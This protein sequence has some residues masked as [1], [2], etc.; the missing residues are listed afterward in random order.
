MKT[1]RMPRQAVAADKAWITSLYLAS[2]GWWE[3][4]NSCY[5]MS[6]QEVVEY[7]FRLTHFR[8][9]FCAERCI[10]TER[11]EG[12]PG[13]PR[14]S[15]RRRGNNIHTAERSYCF[16]RTNYALYREEKQLPPESITKIL[17]FSHKTLAVQDYIYIN[18]SKIK[19]NI[20]LKNYS[21][22]LSSE[23]VRRTSLWNQTSAYFLFTSSFLCLRSSQ[24]NLKV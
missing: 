22:F 24:D 14:Q 16:N 9:S 1:P 8:C 3:K 6:V 20:D 5:C 10:C 7:C 19:E 4:W 11:V 12:G 17:I 15:R 13:R 2:V 23:Y 21:R 18:V